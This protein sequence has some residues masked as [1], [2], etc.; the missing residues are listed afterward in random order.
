MRSWFAAVVLVVASCDDAITLEVASDRPIPRSLDAIC[1]G[2]AD[3]REIGGHLGQLYRLQGALAT[4]PQTLRVDP[5]RADS[6]FLWV[7]GDRGGVP[8]TYA[9]AKSDFGGDVRIA[10]DRCPVGRAGAPAPMG[11][12]VGPARARLVASHGSGNLVVALG[13]AVVARRR[14][15]GGHV[16]D[17]LGE[18]SLRASAG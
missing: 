2:I 4:L 18:D 17:P 3:T 8:V 7:R 14:R 5:G 13:A 10:L 16:V 9:S 15:P 12:P 1:V 11:N 6:A